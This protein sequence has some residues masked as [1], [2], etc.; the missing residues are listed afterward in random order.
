M[1]ACVHIRVPTY[2]YE[3]SYIQTVNSFHKND[4]YGQNVLYVNI[5]FLNKFYK[6]MLENLMI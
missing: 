4:I 6:R 2:T 3:T 5:Y 1:H